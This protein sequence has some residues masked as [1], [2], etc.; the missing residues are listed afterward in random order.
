MNNSPYGNGAHQGPGSGDLAIVGLALGGLWLLWRLLAGKKKVFISYD[1]SEDVHYKHLL[2]AW[3]KNDRFAFEFDNRSPNIPID[4]T[5]AHVIKA[6]LTKLMKD[7]D[8][9][10]VIVGHKTHGSRWVN[11]EVRRAL[12]ADVH[13]KLAVVKIDRDYESPQALLRS[14][15]AWAY[16]FT[17]KSVIE[18]LNRAATGNQMRPEWA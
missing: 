4:S 7:A 8:Y 2:E 11:W 1:H 16:S 12:Q 3:N 17:E 13:L 9:M 15:A 5:D 6:G 14:G 18:V 10:L